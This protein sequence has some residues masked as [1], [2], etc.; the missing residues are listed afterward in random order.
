MEIK[1]LGCYGGQLPRKRTTSFLIEGTTLVDAGGV[2]DALGIEDQRHIDNILVSHSHLDHV[3]DIPM[4]ADNVIG[5]RPAPITVISH[6]PVIDA[7]ANHVMNNV[8][9]PDFTVIPTKDQPVVAY[10]VEP[11]EHKFKVGELTV[12]FVGVKHPVPTCGMFITKG[13]ATLL[14]TADTGPTERIWQKAQEYKNTL[15]AVITEV[16]FPDYMANLSL[17]SGHLSP[18]HLPAELAKLG[19]DDI[20]VY[21]Y[22]FKPAFE[23]DLKKEV[24]ALKLKHVRPLVQDEVLVL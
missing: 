5:S 11:E 7:L 20:P 6:Q 16:S 4:L 9:W 1:I 24:K 10:R 23:I 13:N 2:T 17:M 19:R 21:L 12:E 14:Y 15:R 22:H 18:C 8:V 3:K